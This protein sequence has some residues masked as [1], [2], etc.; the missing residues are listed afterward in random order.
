MPERDFDSIYKA[1]SRLVYWAVYRVLNEQESTEDVAQNVFIAV[2]K[3]MDTAASLP[4]AQ[5]KGWLYRISVNAALDWKRRGSHELLSD[6]P[7]GPEVA[8]HGETP[9]EAAVKGSLRDAVRSALD[10]VDDVYRET[11]MLFYYSELSVAEISETLGISEGT[12]KSRLA[13]GRK[14]LAALL[15]K[16]GVDYE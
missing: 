6:E 4:E 13:R 5:L 15:K 1:Y 12:V 10:E 16:K 2:L 3:N 11:L 9:E 7:L 8:D 14:M